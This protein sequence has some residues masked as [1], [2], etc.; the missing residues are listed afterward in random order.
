MAFK[1]F[2]QADIKT[3][4][5]RVLL[6]LSFIIQAT[7]DIRRKLQKLGKEP[8]IPIFNLVEE[9]N[10]VFLNRDWEE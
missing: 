9:A 2:T 7:P 1:N 6:A 10:R 8:D 4:E 3:M 5:G